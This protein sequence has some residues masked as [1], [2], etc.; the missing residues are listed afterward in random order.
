MK[1]FLNKLSVVM[2]IL[3]VVVALPVTVYLLQSQKFNFKIN[4]FLNDEPQSVFVTDVRGSSVR[5]SWMTEKSVVG[6]VKL[7]EDLTKLSTEKDSVSFHSLEVNN[8]EPGKTYTY[9]I[10]SDGVEYKKAE[11][12]F[13]TNS[14]STTAT[15]SYIVYGQV[16]SKD[17]FSVQNSGLVSLQLKDGDRYSQK[18]MAVINKVGGYQF[19]I[20]NLV[21]AD[22]S[23]SFNYKKNLE[24]IEEVYY[25][26]GKTAIKKQFT[27]DFSV[28]HQIANIYLGDI[29]IDIIPGV[30]G[31]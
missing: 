15:Q 16:F 14:A 25:E 23:D 27:M 10:L 1:N 9:S 11:Y 2:S 21:N 6:M 4:A 24:V 3:F 12:S 13:A 22:N 17:G 5:I 19:N 18:I 26:I 30:N 28:N 8:L 20:A 29:N 31:N 7:S